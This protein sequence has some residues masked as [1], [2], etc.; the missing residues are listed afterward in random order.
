MYRTIIFILDSL[1]EEHPKVGTVLSKYLQAEAKDKKTIENLSPAVYK[2]LAVSH[3]P[4]RLGLILLI[5]YAFRYQRS[6]IS[7]IVAYILYISLEFLF[8]RHSTSTV[9][10]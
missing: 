7:A 5:G 10:L 8:R 3:S 2:N 9:F 6:P 1:G 4:S